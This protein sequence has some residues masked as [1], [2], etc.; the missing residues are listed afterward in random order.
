[1]VLFPDGQKFD[2]FLKQY[3]AVGLK[4]YLNY[5]AVAE[6]TGGMEWEDYKKILTHDETNFYYNNY[7]AEVQYFGYMQSRIFPLLDKKPIQQAL[8]SFKYTTAHGLLREGIGPGGATALFGAQTE[9]TVAVIDKIISPIHKV[10]IS[11]DIH[12]MIHERID[13]AR[14]GG[15]NWDWIKNDLTPKAFWDYYDMWLGG[16]EIAANVHGADTPALTHIECIDRMISSKAESGVATHVSA[17]T[18]GDIWWDG[19]GAGVMAIDRSSATT[20]DAQI[21]LP[22]TPGTNE[23]YQILEEVDD[24]MAVAKKY[25]DNERYIALTTTAV[26]NL[27]K[28]EMGT[29]Q[30]YDGS[31][32]KVAFGINGIQTYPGITAGR[33]VQAIETCGIKVPLFTSD[34]LPTLNSVYTTAAAGSL[35]LIDLDAMFIRVD[36]PATYLE[37]GFGVE[38]LHQDYARSRAMLFGLSQLVCTKFAPHAA[39][40]W[41]AV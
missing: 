36:I 22:T 31:D 23:N 40:K 12:S 26:A 1:M 20:W 37:T 28:D 39:L 16:Y 7:M 25:S 13:M 10:T 14:R 21:K 8:D 11:R 35:Y 5:M 41:I 2:D 24:L 27:I 4:G 9:P 15:T 32:V 33:D 18:D 38:M 17:V 3:Y 19:S 30:R 6:E 29:S 34:M